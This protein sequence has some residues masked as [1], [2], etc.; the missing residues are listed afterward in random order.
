MKLAKFATLAIRHGLLVCEE[1][2]RDGDGK[3]WAVRGGKW[4]ARYYPRSGTVHV[5]GTVGGFKAEPEAA[6]LAALHGPPAQK[7]ARSR[8]KDAMEARTAWKRE[9]LKRPDPRCHYCKTPLTRKTASIDHVIP[10]ARRGPDDPSNW[11]LA[12]H[13]CNQGFGCALKEAS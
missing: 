5:A 13:P 11:V 4:E 12:C 10:I 6:I 2:C 1:D 8:S 9:Q 3:C 7:R